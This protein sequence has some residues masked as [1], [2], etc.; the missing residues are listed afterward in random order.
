MIK[1]AD[2]I[3]RNI[4]SASLLLFI[5]FFL[6]YFTTLR[7]LFNVW[8]TNDDYS[9]GFL[10][11]IISIYLIWERRNEISKAI[12]SVNW[13][14]AIPFF[15]L[16]AMAV[17]GIL[18]SS[19]SA[20]QPTIP[21]ILLSIVLFCFGWQMFQTLFLPLAFLIF[22][23][24]LPPVVE[25]K[26]GVPLKLISTKFGAA[27]LRLF[28]I[29]VFVEGN[30]LDI[31]VTQLQVVDAC[32]GLRFILPLLALGVVFAYFFEKNR[33]KQVV[34]VLVTIPIAIITNGVRIG[35]TGIL[36]Y[37]YGSKVAEGFFHGFS[38][39]V[40]FLFALAL[41][42]IFH[43]LFLR[44][45]GGKGKT[46]NDPVVLK[47]VSDDPV[48][49]QRK[50]SNLLPVILCSA[51]FIIFG[52]LSFTTSALPGLKINGGLSNFP[53]TIKDWQGK[54]AVIDTEMVRLSGAED[55]L[56][57]TYAVDGKHAV[58]LYMGYRG[59][60]FMESANFFHSPNVCLPPSG[61]ITLHSTTRVIKDVPGFSNITVSKMVI[62]KM[63]HKQLVYYWFQ[64]K[65]RASND[66]N[67]N[68]FHLAL[69]AIGRDNTHDLFIRPITPIYPGESVEDA[70]KR[71]D[72]FVRDMMATLLQFLK[73]RQ[74]TQ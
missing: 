67:I 35:A 63:D 66:V 25:T 2:P 10:I 48:S 41:L 34:L 22:M 18:G 24:P 56:D 26:I 65:N 29:P 52:I 27:I 11:P 49:L 57:I 55:A 59:S 72:G 46:K 50:S 40:V 74:V 20:V 47:R 68:R 58:S 45:I 30:V 7:A 17:Y 9:Y 36:A 13:L 43:F 4:C 38:G 32:A 60:P 69:H 51:G 6:F 28:G 15:L 14:G 3:K 71:M 16:L 70:E 54:E 19:G 21:L 53:K 73:E 64:T 31:G 33:W 1:A 8:L 37:Q 39:W 62:E 44:R 61:W 12:V 5:C 23:I 42:G